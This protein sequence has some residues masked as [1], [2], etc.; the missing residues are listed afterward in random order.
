MAQSVINERDGYQELEASE[1]LKASAVYNDDIAPTRFAERTWTRWHIAALWVGMA[2]CVPTYTLGGV[3]TSYFGLSVPEALIVILLANILVLVP[4]VLNAFPGTT[5]GIPFPVLLRSSFGIQGSNI[6]AVIRALIACGWFGIQTLFGGLAIHLLFAQV[7]PGW[8]SLGG[9]G[10]V[11]GFVLFWLLN[12]GIVLRGFDSLKLLET[13]AAPLLVLVGVGLLFWAG[14]KVD[15][16]ALMTAAPSRP[17]GDSLWPWFF[18]GLTAMVGFWAT[19]SLN[20]P[21]F[22]RYAVSQRDQIIGQIIGLPLTM[23]LFAS[24]GVVLTAASPALV[25]QSLSDPIS[26]IGAIHSPVLGSLA[27]LVIILATVSTNTA[28]NIVSPTNDLQNLFPR[29]INFRRGVLITGVIG[30]L[31]MAW[32]LLRKLGWVVSEVGLDSLYSNWLLGYSS[33]LGP[34]AG[35]MVVDYFL[36]RRQRLDL[37]QLY[38]ANSRLYGRFNWRALLAFAI[39]VAVTLVAKLSGHALWI[40][41]YGWFV[42]GFSGGLLHWLFSRHTITDAGRA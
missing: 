26:L 37:I 36:I 14:P 6:P 15:W 11:I 30:F 33:L 4:L 27:L 10:E 21:D 16:P 39:P 18:G 3:L 38:T 42:G 13:L 32:E 28:A 31:L 8:A 17:A 19:L 24:L 1:E 29:R 23:L 25:G 7:L 22:S 40:Y 9:T 20:I 34:I 2:I 35:I 41:N 5:Y 12:I